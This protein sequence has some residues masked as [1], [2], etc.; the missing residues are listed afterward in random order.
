[1]PESKPRGWKASRGAVALLIV[2]ALALS[3]LTCW[4]LKINP[5]PTTGHALDSGSFVTLA[6]IYFFVLYLV[7]ERLKR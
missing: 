1:M 3:A 7:V 5:M 2:G 6:F 4:L